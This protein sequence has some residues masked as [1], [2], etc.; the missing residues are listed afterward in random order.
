MMALSMILKMGRLCLISEV[1]EGCTKVYGNLCL[2]KG[3]SKIYVL[4]DRIFLGGPPSNHAPGG[5]RTLLVCGQ[6]GMIN[7]DCLKEGYRDLF[8]HYT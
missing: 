3:V 8:L 7:F 6:G 2:N 1:P 5:T 4:G